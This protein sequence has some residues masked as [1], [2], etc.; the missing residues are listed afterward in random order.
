[1]PNDFTIEQAADLAKHF[2]GPG[3]LTGPGPDELRVLT[4]PHAKDF[5]IGPNWR[6]VFRAA[7]VHLPLRPQFTAHSLRVMHGAR[8]IC[9]AVSSTMAKR[10]AAALNEHDPDRR[11]I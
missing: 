5:H 7:G 3:W 4:G 2:L 8:A 11:G 10:I 6:G 9:T 1:M